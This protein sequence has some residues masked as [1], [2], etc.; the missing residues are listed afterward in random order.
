[1]DTEN[2]KIQA[3]R[4]K[5]PKKSE[6]M[7]DKIKTYLSIYSIIKGVRINETEI[8]ILA[9]FITEGISR[10]TKNNLLK[11]KVV[12]NENVLSNNLSKMRGKGLLCKEGYKEVVNADFR[13][14]YSKPILWEV[15]LG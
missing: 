6:H 8:I 10:E 9:A 15:I 4:I 3:I 7:I 11:N 2:K 1:M 5:T 13:V 12:K 14:D